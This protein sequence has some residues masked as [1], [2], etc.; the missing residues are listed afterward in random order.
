MGRRRAHRHHNELTPPS[1]RGE[2]VM[3]AWKMYSS[4]SHVIEPPDLW[5]TR[6]VPQF[7]DRAPRVMQEDDG[8]WWIVDGHR[9]NSFQGGAQAGKR[10]EHQEALRPAAR[11]AEVRPGGYLPE[12]HLADNE[13]DGIYGS[14]LYPTEGLQLYAVP[15]SALLSAVFRVYNDWIADFCSA[16]PHRL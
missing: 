4:D 15:D 12:A 16:A 7:R 5:T 8:D 3:M 11:F 10:F 14:V 9:T 6:I 2:R 13:A 1:A